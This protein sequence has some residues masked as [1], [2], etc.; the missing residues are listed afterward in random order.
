VLVTGRFRA[1]IT[2]LERDRTLDPLNGFVAFLLSKAYAAT[3]N[4]AAAI[5]E[6]DRGMKLIGFQ[7]P[8]R[9]GAVLNALATRDRRQIEQRLALVTNA[10]M[11]P[12]GFY[13]AMKN[14]LDDPAE[15]LKEL[16]RRAMA[17]T[18]QVLLSQNAVWMAY[19][20]DP[21]GALEIYRT[22]T[23]LFRSARRSAILF[24]IWSPLMSD[25]R[26]LPGFKDLARDMG[27]VDYWR[28]YGWGDLCKPVGTDD[29]EC[30]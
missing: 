21:A 26:K 24:D 16:R 22:H 27:L 12:S 29:F 15:A 13:T 11:D 28:T 4:L 14:R 18:N 7:V 23:D 6:D 25:M 3:G 17:D 5:A 2:L 1:A 20:G 10:E 9:G 19:F 8:V 30:S